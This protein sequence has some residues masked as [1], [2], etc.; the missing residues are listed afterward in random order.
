MEPV[1]SSLFPIHQVGADGFSWWVGQ[2]E[3][4]KNE[5]PKK[6]GRYRVRIVGQHLKDCQ[7]TPSDQLPWANVMMPVTSPFTDGGTTGASVELKKGNWVVGFYLDNDRQKPLI[8]GSVGHTAGATK[9]ENVDKDPN[10]EECLAFTTFLDPKAN[11][12]TDAPFATENK[13]SGDKPATSSGSSDTTKVGEAGQIAAAVPEQMPAAFLGLFAE[14]S[15][16][17]PTGGKVCVEIANPNCGSDNDLKGGLTSIVGDMLK[18]SQQSGGALGQ[19]YVSQING[20]LNDYINH[21]MEYV[22]KAVRLVKSFVARVKGEIVKLIREGVDKLVDLVLYAE[23]ATT[24]A[25][26]NVNTGPV[27]PDLGVEPFQP[28]TKKESRIKPI[29]DVVNDV[30][31]DLGCSMEDLTDKIA[32]WLTDLLLGYLMDAFS[33][34]ACLVDNLVN[35][36]LN[37][38]LGFLT[39]LLANILGP[40]QEI[41]QLIASPLDILGKAIATVLGLLGI[42]CD[43][44]PDK[45]QNTIKECTDCSN[46][47]EDEED[48]LDKLIAEVENGALDNS[49]YACEESYETSYLDTLPDNNITFIGGIL[50]PGEEDPVDKSSPSDL[51]IEYSSEDIEVKEGEQAVFTITRSGNVSKSSSVKVTVLGGTAIQGEDYDKLFTG[52]SIGFA[53]GATSKKI[54][55]DTY[56]DSVDE[57]PE[58]FYIKLDPNVTPEGL[59]AKF[60]QGNVF[61]CTI[62]DESSSGDGGDEDDGGDGDGDVQVPPTTTIVKPVVIPPSIGSI[63][64]LLPEYVVTTDKIYYKEGEQ[65]C[66]NISTK[67]VKYFGPYYWSIEGDVDENDIVEGLAGQFFLSG[68]GTASVCVTI[69]ENDDNDDETLN[70]LIESISFFIQDTTAY[71]TVFV[72]GDT[73]PLLIRPQWNVDSDV[74]Y[75]TEGETAS[76]T[77]SATLIPDGTN[78]TYKLEGDITR[79]DIVGYRLVSSVDVDAN[80]LKVIGGQCIVPITAA[81]NGAPLRAEDTE[82]FNFIVSSWN[83]PLSF[84]CPGGDTLTNVKSLVSGEESNDLL[85]IVPGM[86]IECDSV[87]IKIPEGTTV[88]NVDYEENTI[89]LSS[90]VEILDGSLVFTG[91]VTGEIENVQETVY[92]APDGFVDD[93]ELDTTPTY[94]VTSDKLEYHEGETIIYT[95]TTTNVPNG[96]KLQYT[97]Y[98]ESISASDFSTGSLFGS[99]IVINNSSKIYIG[100]DEDLDIEEDETLSFIISGTGAATDVIIKDTTQERLDQDE[101]GKKKGCFEKPIAGQPITDEK[102]SIISIPIVSKGCP[103]IFPPKVI[104]SGPG[105]GASAIALL[106]SDGRVSEVRVTRTGFGYRV[107]DPD[108]EDLRCVIDSF[109]ITKPGINYTSEPT[110]YINGVSGRAQSIIDERGYLISVQPTDRTTTYKQIPI[111]EIIGGGGSGARVLPSIT[112]L[113]NNEYESQEYAKIGTGKY[114]DCP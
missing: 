76:F 52:S 111:I 23:V 79:Q 7:A 9:K 31:D 17:N 41:L 70:D 55:F 58:K 78:F 26:G 21:G 94:F 19:F 59:V 36:I 73:D 46:G 93:T 99:F 49:T 25:L 81:D 48:W 2:I 32:S 43:G 85:G 51:F 110:V 80:P 84:N 91:L 109:T 35:G 67:N 98:G 54:S 96:T 66:F 62:L 82:Y 18:A 69:A 60:A 4:E 33:N 112:C 10:A 29:I 16:T 45:C 56:K 106:D 6:S 27:A 95:V 64:P 13:R 22:N 30:L 65:V 114:I 63:V 103:F 5:D 74:N 89:E 8:M 39:E 38:I 34:A 107:R 50:V 105:Y 47:E 42:S 113:D 71:T 92:I 20:E 61:E 102:G 24:D 11:P 90:E 104:I 14:A 12:Q 83:I 97:L 108:N 15:T 87:F 68:D 100:V 57:K 37:E 86:T 40:I 75:I 44:P 3:S 101:F 88:T 28:I 77:V 53:A 1:L 72:V